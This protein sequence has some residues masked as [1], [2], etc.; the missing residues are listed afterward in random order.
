MRRDVPAIPSATGGD[1]S[2]RDIETLMWAQACEALERAERL[3]RQFFQPNVARTHRPAWKPPVDIFESEKSIRIVIALPGV[4]SE[5]L[6]IV[7]RNNV[8][9]ISGERPLPAGAGG[10]AIRRME[11]PQG[12]FERHIQL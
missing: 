12:H 8:L 9:I 6:E 4:E 10:H 5:H 7:F 3:Q 2:S 11:I 1:M